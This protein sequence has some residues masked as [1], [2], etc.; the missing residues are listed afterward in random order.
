MLCSDAEENDLHGESVAGG[1]DLK[2]AREAD[3]DGDGDGGNR[4]K[5]AVWNR[6]ASGDR[7]SVD[8]QPKRYR[9][10][11]RIEENMQGRPSNEDW[12]K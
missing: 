4:G 1:A 11:R 8:L 2:G 7:G 6:V 10:E 9:R 12:N 3:D 5:F